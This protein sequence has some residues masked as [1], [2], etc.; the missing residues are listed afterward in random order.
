MIATLSNLFIWVSIPGAWLGLLTLIL[1]EVVLSIDNIVFLTIIIGKLPPGQQDKARKAGLLLAMMMRLI[2][3]MSISW[4]MGLTNVLFTLFAHGVSWRDLI[5]ILGG[6]FLILKSSHEIFSTV[7]MT[8]EDEL[9]KGN[10]VTLTFKVA[11]VQI[12]AIDIIF[13]LDSVITAVG[14]IQYITIMMI[15]VVISVGIMFIF[16]KPIGDFINSHS[17]I[18]IL[19]LAFLIMIGIVL[20]AEGC[21]YYLPKTFVYGGMALCVLMEMLNI[22]RDKNSK[23]LGQCPTCGSIIRH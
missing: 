12:V 16:V 1:L 8:S 17:S 14:M 21:G 5:L 23:K 9:K 15:A 10:A 18:K 7:E 4:V 19:A 13:S 2:L 6:I 20:M 22:R 3:L 11:L